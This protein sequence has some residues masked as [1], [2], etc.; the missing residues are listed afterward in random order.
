MSAER[1]NELNHLLKWSRKEGHYAVL[2]TLTHQH[3]KR[4]DLQTQVQGMADAQ[5]YMRQSKT[6]RGLSIVGTVQASEI[7]YGSNGWHPHNHMIVIM[8]AD[9]SEE[10]I[11]QLETLR[12]V[13]K[14]GL[15]K[16]RMRGNHAAFDLKP[17]DQIGEYIAKFGAAEELT[18]DQQKRG[19]NGSKTV[20]QLL[21]EA[22]ENDCKQSAALWREFAHCYFGRKQLVW[23]SGLKKLAQIEKAKEIEETFGDGNGPIVKREIVREWGPQGSAWKEASRRYVSLLAAAADGGEYEDLNKAEYG[24]T[25]AELWRQDQR[26]RRQ[27]LVEDG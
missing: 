3:S 16:H 7:T 23:S 6:Y 8:K 11:A 9:T 14:R 18:L 21:H 15:N 4:S 13:W 17:A 27:A 5:K 12:A 26:E 2:L 19:R 24:L 10:A 1:A 25:D 20:W 22:T